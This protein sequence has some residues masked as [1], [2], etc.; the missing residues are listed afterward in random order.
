MNCELFLH[1]LFGGEMGN[2]AWPQTCRLVIHLTGS[3]CWST[4]ATLVGMSKCKINVNKGRL[5]YYIIKTSA[6]FEGADKVE[7]IIIIFKL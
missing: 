5:K 3:I 2:F 4:R 6:H 7:F 1:I